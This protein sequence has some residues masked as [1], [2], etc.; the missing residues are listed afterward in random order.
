MKASRV[1]SFVEHPAMLILAATTAPTQEQRRELLDAAAAQVASLATWIAELR[2]TP[3]PA[4]STDH[5]KKR[6]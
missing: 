3:P 1:V 4:P 5:S 2:A 6:N